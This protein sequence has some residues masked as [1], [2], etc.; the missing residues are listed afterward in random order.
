MA[1]FIPAQTMSTKDHYISFASHPV[2][3]LKY[4]HQTKEEVFQVPAISFLMQETKK[5][6][7]I[8]PDRGI[9]YI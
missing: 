4:G 8:P 6:K 9:F 2:T 1:I 7:K 5:L 3:T